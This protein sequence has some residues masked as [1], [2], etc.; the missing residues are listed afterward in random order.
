[1]WPCQLAPDLTQFHLR[2]NF[3]ER[4]E[5]KICQKDMRGLVFMAWILKMKET[6]V[7]R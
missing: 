4:T 2:L 1:M 3:P 5:R 7:V 6:S